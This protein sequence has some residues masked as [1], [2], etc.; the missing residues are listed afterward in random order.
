[1]LPAEKAADF[2]KAAQQFL[3]ASFPTVQLN[4][5][6][7]SIIS[8]RHY[9]R[10]IALLDDAKAKGA[11]IISLAPEGEPDFDDATRKIAPQIVLDVSDEML[12]M[13][14]EIFGPLLPVKTYQKLDEAIDYINVNPRPLAAYFF[15]NNTEQQ[16]LI[17]ARTTSG[18]LV[19]NDVM[20]HAAIDTLPFGG[21]GASG[22]GAYHGIHGFRRFT[23]QKPV[24]VQSE[25]GES[26]LRLR[27]PY[28]EKQVALAALFNA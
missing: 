26:N 4:D 8:Q 11:K 22:I 21:V 17:A 23:H 15:G 6:Y 25:A 24:V 18:A 14:E 28:Q 12:I 16:E 5:D 13:Q 1:M 20:T 9:E 3:R 10:L 19:I 27:A 7:T 2:A